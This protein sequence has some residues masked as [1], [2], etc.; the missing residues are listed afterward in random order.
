MQCYIAQSYRTSW[1]L[2]TKAKR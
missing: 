1:I 2:K